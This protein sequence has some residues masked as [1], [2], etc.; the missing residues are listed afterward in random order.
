MDA[1]IT[2]RSE[3]VATLA[4]RL[5]DVEQCL[6]EAQAPDVRAFL[7][8]IQQELL[9]ELAALPSLDRQTKEAHARDH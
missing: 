4:A 1:V 8:G 6:S 3:R 2:D 5:E 9:A 7:S